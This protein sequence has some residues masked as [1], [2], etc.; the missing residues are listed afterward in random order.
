MSIIFENSV[1]GRRG[2]TLPESDVPIRHRIDAKYLRSKNP[3]LCELSELQVVRHFTALSRKNYGVDTNFYPLGSCTMKYNPKVNEKISAM[4]GFASLHPL[5]PQLSRGGMLTQ[6]ALA[7]IFELEQLLCEISGMD[8]YTAHPMAGAHGELTGMMIIAAYHKDKGNR[9]TEVLIP[10]EAHGTNPSSAA[11][12]HPHAYEPAS[13]TSPENPSR[14]DT[15][16]GERRGPRSN[17]RQSM[18]PT[19]GRGRSRDHRYGH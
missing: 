17:R 16:R 8:A 2:V 18:P 3:E 15:P 11:I 4:D 12:E 5:L 1:S 6:G 13:T 7:V 19:S 14:P 9:K 10:D